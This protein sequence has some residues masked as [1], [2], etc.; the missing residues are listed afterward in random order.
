MVDQIPRLADLR[1]AAW[2]FLYQNRRK[3][4]QHLYSGRWGDVVEGWVAQA[5]ICRSRLGHEM[6]SARLPLS[7]GSPLRDLAL[8]EFFAEIPSGST[9]AVGEVILTRTAG[10]MPGGIIR[11]GHRFQK[12]ADTTAHPP[13]PGAEYTAEVTVSVAPATISAIIPVI[14]TAPGTE[15]NTY[16]DLADPSMET[17]LSP[18][19]SSDALFD[20]NFSV[21][22]VRAAGGSVSIS[23]TLIRAIARS[24]YTGRQGPNSWA[25]VAG[26]LTAGRGV[27]C[28]QYFED[29]ANSRGVV[30]VADAS[31]ASSD[32]LCELLAQDLRGQPGRREWLG[33]GSKV[34]VLGVRNYSIS[35]VATLQTREAVDETSIIPSLVKAARYYFDERLGWWNYRTNTLAAAL[36]A[37]DSRI[38]G[39]TMVSIQNTNGS[40]TFPQNASKWV[41]HDDVWLLHYLVADDGMRITFVTV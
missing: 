20:T 23:D 4:Y 36:C 10:S 32:R 5:A 26:V 29:P 21:T 6:L 35:I 27:E 40:S 13:V 19:S 38:I 34:D 17:E 33:F 24:C 3:A 2:W 37:A 41:P 1:G 12:T 39:C 15:A 31:W 18:A 25:A 8:S 22:G 28:A 14:A 9:R 16:I 11:A 7:A 30:Y